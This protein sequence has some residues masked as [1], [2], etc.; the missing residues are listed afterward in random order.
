M[1]CIVARIS[2]DQQCCYG[3]SIRRLKIYAMQEKFSAVGGKLLFWR[4]RHEWIQAGW[5]PPRVR[6]TSWGGSLYYLHPPPPIITPS[7]TSPI[8]RVPACLLCSS[9]QFSASYSL[10]ACTV[11]PEISLPASSLTDSSQVPANHPADNFAKPSFLTLSPTPWAG[12]TS[13][14]GR[15]RTW[16]RCTGSAPR[17]R[18]R[19]PRRSSS[20]SW[21]ERCACSPMGCLEGPSSCHAVQPA[22]VSSLGKDF[23]VFGTSVKTILIMIR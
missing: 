21:R 19:R 3:R 2:L 10:A 23:N 22:V 16:G 18:R 15:W 8:R 14:A 17:S 9:W 4:S 11:L 5:R 6:V 12:P 1:N 13:Q 20:A 7:L